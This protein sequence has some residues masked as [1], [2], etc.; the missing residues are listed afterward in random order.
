MRHA[1][2]LVSALLLAAALAAAPAQ[3]A[4]RV[5]ACEPEWGALAT[6]I[7]GDAVQVYVA[8]T[9]A[10]DPHH[11]DARPSLVAQVRKADLLV[12]TGASLETGWLPVLLAR[13]ANPALKGERLFFAAEKVTRLGVP[14]GAVDRSQGD[15]HSEGNPHVHL[16]PRRM[17]TIGQSLAATLATLDAAH[18]DGY[19]A[20]AAAF[21]QSMNA[22]IAGWE[23]SAAAVRGKPVVVYHDAWPY[24]VDWLGLAQIATLEPLP[25]VP[26]SG[27]HLAQVARLAQERGAWGV[28]HTTYDDRKAVQWIAQQGRTCAIELPYSVGGDPQAATLRTFYDTLVSRIVKGCR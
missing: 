21:T 27:Q 28:L 22:A 11:V 7:G 25:G 4:L 14:T 16:D 8:T 24:L 20:R 15:V 23:K 6:E 3:A 5:F 26:P 17:V 13:S 18:A 12:C 10:Q 9:A 19:R 1:R 2:P